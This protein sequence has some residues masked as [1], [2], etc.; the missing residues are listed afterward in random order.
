MGHC[1]NVYLSEVGETQVV[2]FKHGM[3][4]L[5]IYWIFKCTKYTTF[6]FHTNDIFD[7]LTEKEDGAISTIVVRG[8]TDNLMD[9][10]ERAVD[11]GVNTFKVLTRVSKAIC[12]DNMDIEEWVL[13]I[14]LLLGSICSYRSFL[15]SL[16]FFYRINALFQVVVQQRLSW[17]SRSLHMER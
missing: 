8:S 13:L 17:L 5:L 16:W 1:D 6:K 14:V 2:V 7:F 4:I 15:G 3:F 9:D 10:V 12:A 11:D